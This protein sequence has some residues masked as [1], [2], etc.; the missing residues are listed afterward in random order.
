VTQ[1]AIACGS[2]G[3]KCVFIHGVLSAF[4]AA[5]V[6]GSAYAASSA[7]VAP[8]GFAAV[9]EA[10][11]VGVEYWLRARR[12]LDRPG[13]GMSEVV[14]QCIADFGARIHAALFES[15]APRFIIATS[16]VVNPEAAAQTQGS[17]ARSLGRRL[18]VSAARG[19]RSW[20]DANLALHLFDTAP[21]GTAT[22]LSSENFDSV[23]YASTRMLHAWTVPAWVAGRAYVDA[24]Y[25]CACPVVEIADA[26]PSDEIIAIAAEHGPLYR[27]LFGAELLPDTVRG[28]PVHVV[29]PPHD[30]RDL[31]VDYAGAT[32]DGLVAAYRLGEAQ[33][34]RLLDR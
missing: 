20:A 11:D 5:G 16:A 8:A 27:D 30:L 23:A 32:E 22:R 18:L 4:E 33:G 17:A 34:R 7:S 9:G 25:T 26:R 21:D 31:G 10:R 28:G 6:R 1:L 13:A 15:A 24:S 12:I 19:D 2:G 14:L 3:F 29:Q